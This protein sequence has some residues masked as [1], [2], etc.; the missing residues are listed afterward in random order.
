[1][2]VIATGYWLLFADSSATDHGC[3]SGGD[4]VKE[5]VIQALFSREPLVT[6]VIFQNLFQGLPGLFGGQLRHDLFHMHNELTAEQTGQ[7]LEKILEDNARDK[8]FT[9]EEGL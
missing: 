9:A 2:L 3:C 5:P 6:C 7:T 4:V 8:W 1:V